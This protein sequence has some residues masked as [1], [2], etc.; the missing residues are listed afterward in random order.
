MRTKLLFLFYIIILTSS[1]ESYSDDIQTLIEED[2]N[3]NFSDEDD[4]DNSVPILNFLGDSIIDYWKNLEFFFPGYECHNYGWSG[5]GID[6]FLGKINIEL[7]ENTNCIVEIGTN[8]MRK[9]INNGSIDNYIDHYIDVLTSIKA[10]RIFLLS[11]LPRNRQKDGNFNFNDYYPEINQKI[12]EQT[13]TRMN[14]V[15]YI[16]LYDTFLKNGKMNEEYTYDGLHPNHR[17][18]EVMATIIN[19]YIKITN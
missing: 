8:D 13:K 18:Y 16:P 17:G 19:E 11:L 3:T 4:K 10:K 1:C 5:K 14:N 7:L 6:S 12:E 9:V 15:V 2:V